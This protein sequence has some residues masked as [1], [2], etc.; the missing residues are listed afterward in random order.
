MNVH[1]HP[2]HEIFQASLQPTRAGQ[3]FSI[4]APYA[5]PTEYQGVRV[6]VSALGHGKLHLRVVTGRGATLRVLD[7]L[8]KSNDLGVE[9]LAKCLL[10]YWIAR[11]ARNG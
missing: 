6:E 2:R 5:S 4:Y 11:E 8:D 7:T 9:L 3:P 1:Y 10:T